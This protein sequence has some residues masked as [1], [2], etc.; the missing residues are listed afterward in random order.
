MAVVI[1]VGFIHFTVD[2]VCRRV[3][4]RCRPRSSLTSV[5][6]VNRGNRENEEACA[7]LPETEQKSVIFLDDGLIRNNENCN[8]NGTSSTS[9]TT[10]TVIPLVDLIDEPDA[11]IPNEN[12]RSDINCQLDRGTDGDHGNTDPIDMKLTKL[13]CYYYQLNLYRPSILNCFSDK[14]LTFTRS[15]AEFSLL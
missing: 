15:Q 13:A 7:L 4:G 1:A 12:L 11:V 5:L 14:M 6:Y 2:F 9:V 10:Q 3:K 8:N